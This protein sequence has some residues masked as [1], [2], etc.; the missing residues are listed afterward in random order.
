MRRRR[1]F[2]RFFISCCDSDS[3]LDNWI[4]SRS[5]GTWESKHQGARPGDHDPHSHSE[6]DTGSF[7]IED[8]PGPSDRGTQLFI[9]EYRTLA[10]AHL[11]P[12]PGGD[13]A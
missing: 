10:E 4:A 12:T 2:C 11:W 1:R 13:H 9:D 8:M 7:D 6:G 3:D 5:E